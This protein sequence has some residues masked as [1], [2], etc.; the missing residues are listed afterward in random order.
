MSNLI[1][2]ELVSP[3]KKLVSEPYYLAEIPGDDGIFGVMQGHC[4]L[5]SS[6]KP[7]VVRLQKEKGAS[8]KEEIF[9]AGGFADVT[10]NNCTVLAEEAIPVKDLNKESLEQLLTDLNEDINLAEEKTD[11]KHIQDKIDI[12]KAKITAITGL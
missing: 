8:E 1:Q 6:L 9:I 7:G 3:E 12:T 5:L 2:F 11:K 10:A 4:S